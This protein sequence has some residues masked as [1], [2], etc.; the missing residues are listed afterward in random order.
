MLDTISRTTLKNVYNK[1][2]YLEAM[3]DLQKNDQHEEILASAMV[4]Q[5]KK[6]L[7][8][9]GGNEALAAGRQ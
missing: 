7:T 5:K 1:L 8:Q 3:K 9:F 4:D 6:I 2:L